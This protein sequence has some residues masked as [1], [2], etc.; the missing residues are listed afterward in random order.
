MRTYTEEHTV[1]S[2]DE[3]SKEAQEKAIERLYNINVDYDW[4]DGVYYDAGEIGLEITEFDLYRRDIDGK[5]TKAILENHGKT[6][7]TYKLA[8]KW[9]NKHGEDNQDEFT[10]LLLKVYLNILNK[11]Y[12]YLTSEEAI[13]ETIEANEYEFTKEGV[14]V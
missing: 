7:E 2:F 3:L 11:D 13:K 8:E 5:L 6:C 1:Y 10:K 4:W 9:Q 12:E 14:M